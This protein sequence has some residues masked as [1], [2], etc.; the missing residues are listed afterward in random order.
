MDEK[1]KE[2]L[3]L[4]EKYRSRLEDIT[5]HSREDYLKDGLL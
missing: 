4:L 3:K 1:L 5:A 2:Q